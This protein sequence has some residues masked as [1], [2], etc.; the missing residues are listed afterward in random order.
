MHDRYS[1]NSIS[2]AIFAKANSDVTAFTKNSYNSTTVVVATWVNIPAHGSI[3]E[4]TFVDLL[5]P[6]PPPLCLSLIFCLSNFLI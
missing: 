6:P 1:N 4:V 2:A 5:T 3:D